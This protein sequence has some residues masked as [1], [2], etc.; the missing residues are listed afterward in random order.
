MN[1]DFSSENTWFSYIYKDATPDERA[2]YEYWNRLRERLPPELLIKRFTQLF[3]EGMSDKAE[4]RILLHRLLDASKKGGSKH[5]SERPF[6]YIINCCCFILVNYW[7]LHRHYRFAIKDFIELFDQIPSNTPQ[8]PYN[9]QLRKWLLKYRNS[10]DFEGLKRFVQCFISVHEIDQQTQFRGILSRYPFL[11]ETPEIMPAN[12]LHFQSEVLRELRADYDAK[13]EGFVFPCYQS[14]REGKM[15]LPHQG[16]QVL[17][18]VEVARGFAQYTLPVGA[19]GTHA[20]AARRFQRSAKERHLSI[21]QFNQ[22]F[23]DFLEEP[24]RYVNLS[25]KKIA[26]FSAMVH[27]HLKSLR[28]KGVVS[29]SHSS[30]HTYISRNMIKRMVF[31]ADN[32]NNHFFFISI[33]NLFD[34]SY[35]LVVGLLLRIAHFCKGA[36]GQLERCLAQLFRHYE[37]CYVR[38]SNVDWLL[39]IFEHINL[40]F[41]TNFGKYACA[42]IAMNLG[43]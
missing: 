5:G 37:N 33:L 20:Q 40:A 36:K 16:L 29:P 35:E 8:N 34:H 4:I 11:L 7:A 28:P 17:S 26:S 38:G 9:K 31:E 12:R 19:T 10:Q 21:A 41:A 1:P 25:E 24:A 39:P 30:F 14:W 15:L 32:Q 22:A 43:V 27:E 13:H 23:C 3:F 2:L 18:Q 42:P 6:T